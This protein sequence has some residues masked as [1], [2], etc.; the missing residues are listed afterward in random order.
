MECTVTNCNLCSSDNICYT[1]AAGYQLQAA[2]T[3]N[4]CN[5]QGCALCLNSSYCQNCSTGYIVN[6]NTGK[7]YVCTYPC[8]TC[9]GNSTNYC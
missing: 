5:L 6:I 3:C 2:S 4:I 8:L 1:C 7:C 9:V